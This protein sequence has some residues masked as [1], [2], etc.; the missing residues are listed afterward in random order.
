VASISDEVT[1][2]MNGLDPSNL[3][4]DFGSTQP[5]TELSTRE[6]P[7]GKGRLARK[8]DDFNSICEPIM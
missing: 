1:G 7:G 6:L 5:I 2:F 4:M 3:T 8:A